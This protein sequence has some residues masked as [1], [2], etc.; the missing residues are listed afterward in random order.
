MAERTGNPHHSFLFY[1][2]CA[3][4]LLAPLARGAGLRAIVFA[5]VAMAAA[6]CQMAFTAGA[7][8]G[9]HH[10]I[11]LWPLPQMVMGISFAAASHRMGRA[12]IPV[13]AS[14]LVVLL[15]SGLAV[16][17]Q[18]YAQAV[19]NGGA[20]AWNDAIFPLSDYMKNDAWRSVFCLDWGFLDTLRMLS[21]GKLPVRVGAEQISKPELSLQDHRQLNEM[22]SQPD[23]VFLTHT[24]DFEFSRGLSAR[25]IQYA[26]NAGFHRDSLAVISDSYGRP[27]FEVYRF[28][29]PRQANTL[30]DGRAIGRR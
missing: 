11:L 14:I 27:V 12:G 23:N 18:Y 25:L 19:R 5:M 24:K 9:A 10:V 21:N 13:L 7:G 17:N 26:E 29:G 8:G 30:Q 4:L 2:F 15:G 3:A 1:G 20:M 28:A 22:I 6:W 16:M